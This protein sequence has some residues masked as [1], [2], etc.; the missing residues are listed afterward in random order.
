M[1]KP[2]MAAHEV[3][4][5]G[6][7]TGASDRV[8]LDH[9]SRFLRRKRLTTATGREIVADLPATVSLDHGDALQL[10][11]GTIVEIVAAE[12]DLAAVAPGAG[13]ADMARLAWHIGNRHTPCQIEPSRLLILRDPVLERMVEGLGA[14]VT[15][16]RKRFLHEGRA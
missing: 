1:D 16:V 7:W 10:A 13:G 8:L 4:R 3:L 2:A 11:Y 6:S 12:E 14:K 9:D 5:A 15:P